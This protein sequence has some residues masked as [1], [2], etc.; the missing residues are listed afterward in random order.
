MSKVDKNKIWSSAFFKLKKTGVLNLLPDT[1][2]LK[3]M[4]RATLQRK[5]DLKNPTT[6]N[7]KLQ[8]LKIHDRKDIYTTIVDKYEVKK[9]I[10]KKNWSKLYNP[11][12][13]NLE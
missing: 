8:W 2:Y 9:Y 3:F 10:A 6:F 5:L 12:I 4:F 13:G 11:Y 1:L 7:E